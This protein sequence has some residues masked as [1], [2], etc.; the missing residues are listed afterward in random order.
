V[1]DMLMDPSAVKGHSL[2]TL[3]ELSDELAMLLTAGSDTSSNAVISG[4]Y[5]IC[6][7]KLIYRTLVAE[8]Q[9]AFPHP[10]PRITFES[11]RKLPY[12]VSD[13]SYTKTRMRL[14]KNLSGNLTDGS[15][16]RLSRRRCGW[17]TL[18]LAGSQGQFL[19]KDTCYTAIL[20]RPG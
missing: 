12:L 4:I 3:E 5:Y 14:V 7:H 15:S 10:E 19:L 17:A 2:P 9:G 8:L 18:C 13:I 11:A 6:H 1:I 20:C 16:K